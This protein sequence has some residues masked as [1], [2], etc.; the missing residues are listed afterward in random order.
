MHFVCKTGPVSPMFHAWAFL[1]HS[2]LGLHKIHIKIIIE[3]AVHEV[4]TRGTTRMWWG[5]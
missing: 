3:S 4:R 1:T 5:T 2:A